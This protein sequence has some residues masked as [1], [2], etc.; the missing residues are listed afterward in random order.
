M[1]EIILTIYYLL[2][3]LFCFYLIIAVIMT[4]KMPKMNVAFRTY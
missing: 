3:S 4:D 1:Q 2:Y